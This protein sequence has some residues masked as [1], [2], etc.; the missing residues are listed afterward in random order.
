YFN[1]MLPF[2][3]FAVGGADF[4]PMA[5][6]NNTFGRKDVTQAH[7]T[8]ESIVFECGIQTMADKPGIYRA[9]AAYENLFKNLPTTWNNSILVDGDPGHYV[10][11]ARQNGDNWYV[12][13]L[14][15]EARTAEFNL[16]FLDDGAYTAYIFR[17]SDDPKNTD[18]Q[19]AIITETMTVTKGQTLSIDVKKTGGAVVK[20]V[21]ADA[22]TLEVNYNG[23]QASLFV[24]DEEQKLANLTG[25][26]KAELTPDSKTTLTFLPAVEGRTFAGV[27]VNGEAQ[28]DFTA[29]SYTMT[30]NGLP[31]AA[32]Y[33]LAFTVVNKQILRTVLTAAEA[34]NG[35]EEYLAAV[36][37]VQKKFDAAL[38]NAQKVEEQLDASQKDIDGAWKDLLQ[39]I[40]FLSFAKGDK[41]ALEEA[42]TAAGML[43]EELYT[44]ASWQAFQK[45]YAAAQTVYDD[46]D[47]MDK[48]I[49]EACVSLNKAMEDLEDK[50]DWSELL[51]LIERAEEIEAVLDT[52]YLETGKDAFLKALDEARAMEESASQKE[53]NR[54]AEKLALAMANLRKIP[55]RDELNDLIAEM[56]QVNLNG[57]TRASAATFT[58]ALNDLK[59]AAADE[60]ADD[61]TL[62]T[63][64]YNAVDAKNN[65][66]KAET[67]V[68]PDRKPSGSKGSSSASSNSYGAAGTAVV[69]AAQSTSAQGA[70][71]VSDTTV[72][73]T[74]K[75]GSAYCFKMTVQGGANL[76]PGFT[77]GSGSVLKTQFV[78]KIGNDCYYRVWAVGTPG[79]SS[80]VYTTLPGQNPVKH[81][82]VTIG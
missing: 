26:Y 45:A 11:M 81:C 22:K 62:A 37:S 46:E 21:K 14:C 10:N 38:K 68:T 56:E 59:A 17:D 19:K 50:A 60:T 76:T 7:L 52:E 69:N 32:K 70:Y 53:I 2:T 75:R 41:T 67:P 23:K 79:Q 27:S 42:L 71:V 16:D 5:S 35:G 39:V 54:M 34:L 74:L 18:S 40:Q 28:K 73:F 51:S 25:S 33:D 4:T 64:Y 78:A 12:G 61:K 80:G 30:I 58:Q 8:A 48:E 63:A 66:E 43:D 31:A 20:L 1:C 29:D 9:H 13:I 77:V 57:Y 3:R 24:N 44:S 36:P 6:Y 65:L 47:A 55:S 49:Q 72:N 15:N 82:A